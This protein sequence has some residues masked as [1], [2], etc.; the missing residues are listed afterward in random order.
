MEDTLPRVDA[1]YVSQKEFAERFELPRIP[2]I[3]THALDAWP[4]F[5]GGG[6][7]RAWSW[8]A[9]RERFH[10]HK[11]KVGSDDDGRVTTALCML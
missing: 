9:L 4:A 2:C 1:R 7:E 11:F 3:I 5:G 10:D 6:A 8:A